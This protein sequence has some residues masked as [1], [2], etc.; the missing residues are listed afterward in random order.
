M[1]CLEEEGEEEEE[2]EEEEEIPRWLWRRGWIPAEEKGG[3][4]GKLPLQKGSF[5]RRWGKLRGRSSMEP[6]QISFITSSSAIP[7]FHWSALGLW[8]PYES[9]N[10]KYIITDPTPK[11]SVF[12]KMPLTSSS[13]SS[14]S[15]SSFSKICVLIQ[16]HT[17]LRYFVSSVIWH[18]KSS[19]ML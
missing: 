9:I 12:L 11:L 19:Q 8:R 4:S 17:Y 5:W 16:T 10:R 3:F 2:E 13:S 15:S 18:D 14:S 1:R 7:A 6:A